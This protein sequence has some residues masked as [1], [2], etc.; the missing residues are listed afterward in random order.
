MNI[1]N[2][3]ENKI[4][5]IFTYLNAYE[6]DIEYLKINRNYRVKKE[7]YLINLKD[8]EFIKRIICYDDLMKIPDKNQLNQK[9]NELE[10]LNILSK[11]K[12]IN[13]IIVNNTEELIKLIKEKN[14]YI[15]I[16]KKFLDNILPIQDYQQKIYKLNI[17][18]FI[19]E[20]T[21]GEKNLQT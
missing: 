10:Y 20:L 15:L 17:K 7:G 8:Y 19:L 13:P 3:D 16:D 4:Y 18:Y 1:I 6:K 5:E 11:I 2:N 21:I 14:E 9:L 12:E